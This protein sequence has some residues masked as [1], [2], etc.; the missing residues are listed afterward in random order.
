MVVIIGVVVAADAR[1]EVAVEMHVDAVVE[2]PKDEGE[3]RH[4]QKGFVPSGNCEKWEV[5]G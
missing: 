3:Q 4:R 1:R 2:N 5:N